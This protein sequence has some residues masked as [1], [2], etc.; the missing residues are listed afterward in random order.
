MAKKQQEETQTVF[1][2]MDV[3][4]N[5][6]E[7]FIETHQSKI[8]IGLAVIAAVVVG[9]ICFKS[10][11]LEP[12]NEESKESIFAAEQIFA[13]DS[14]QLALDGNAEIMGFLD[15][16][17]EYG[18]TDAGNLAKAYAGLCYK[19][20]GDN[21]SAIEYLSKFSADDK[22]VQPAIYGAIADAYWDMNNTDKAISYYEKAIKNGNEMIAPFYGKREAM[23]YLSLN[24]NDKA[25][26]ILK[27][28]EKKY[29]NFSEMG[30]VKKFIEY[31]SK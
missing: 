28:I 1:E 27:N 9:I 22:T 17:D 7:A 14:F 10:F 18:S 6:G 2:D 24:Q 13:M 23:L 15:I 12:R 11:Y 4:L 25:L 5:K 21:E 8:F 16:I 31:I 30:E 20:L 3:A 29:P 19:Q 26:D